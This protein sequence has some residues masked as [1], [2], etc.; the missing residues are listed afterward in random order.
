MLDFHRLQPPSLPIT[1]NQQP[2]RYSDWWPKSADYTPQKL[3]KGQVSR[4]PSAS[5]DLAYFIN[6]DGLNSISSPPRHP[7]CGKQ[8][9]MLSA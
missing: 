8:L 9:L 5:R 7:C 2:L 1:S 4:G 3:N 6:A